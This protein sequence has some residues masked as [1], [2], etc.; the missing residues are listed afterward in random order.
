MSN[1]CWQDFK[2]DVDENHLVNNP[3][4]FQ[5][6]LQGTKI[7]VEEWY[8]LTFLII[9]YVCTFGNPFLI[10]STLIINLPSTKKEWTYIKIDF[11]NF[12]PENPGFKT[13]DRFFRTEIKIDILCISCLVKVAWPTP[14]FLEFVLFL[15]HWWL[16]T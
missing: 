12:E 7:R 8:F 10:Q 14:R 16:C 13:Y 9:Y 3:K 6:L 2:T 4:A 11:M 1:L 5:F 15:L